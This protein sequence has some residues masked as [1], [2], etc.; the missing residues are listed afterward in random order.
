MRFRNLRRIGAQRQ[1]KVP[2]SEAERMTVLLL[3]RAGLITADKADAL[4]RGED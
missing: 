3:V 2:G 4:L 1:E